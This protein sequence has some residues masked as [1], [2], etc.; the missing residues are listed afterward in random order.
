MGVEEDEDGT[1]AEIPALVGFV[2][3]ESG[4]LRLTNKR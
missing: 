2:D 1:K 4:K 3:K